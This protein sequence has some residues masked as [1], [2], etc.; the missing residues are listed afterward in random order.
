VPAA[1]WADFRLKATSLTLADARSYRAIAID[2]YY[3]PIDPHYC[4]DSP[5]QSV[6]LRRIQGNHH[7]QK[8]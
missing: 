5:S 8:D 2:P 6:D 1:L 4:L 7:A 3:C